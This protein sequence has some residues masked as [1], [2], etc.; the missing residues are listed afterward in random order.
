MLITIEFKD[1]AL[2][3]HMSNDITW[4]QALLMLLSTIHNLALT[5]VDQVV[6]QQ[7]EESAKVPSSGSN[8]GSKAK[9][10][11]KKDIQALT[12]EVKADVAD[13]I[14]AGISNVLEDISPRDPDLMLTEVAIA[15]MENEIIHKAATEGKTL[16]QALKE[17]EAEL[18][19]SP[20]AAKPS[21]QSH[22]TECQS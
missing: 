2:K 22:Q 18:A 6:K 14:N 5:T 3:L 21:S 19:K 15:T 20:R 9:K 1:G 11:S 10:L 7:I 17:Y 13:M 12:T 4:P 16:K 8:K